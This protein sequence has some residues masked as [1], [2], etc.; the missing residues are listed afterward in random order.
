MYIAQSKHPSVA[1]QHQRLRAAEAAVRNAAARNG[2]VVPAARRE[3]LRERVEECSGG[4]NTVLYNDAGMPG[5]YVRFPAD[6]LA[7]TSAIAAECGLTDGVPHQAFRV[8]GAN[9]GAFFMGKYP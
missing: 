9:T 6:K 7:L 8:N 5:I 4:R 1:E 2:W 3:E